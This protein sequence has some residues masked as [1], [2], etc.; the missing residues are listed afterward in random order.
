MPTITDRVSFPNKE[1]RSTKPLHARVK[2]EWRNGRPELFQRGI[3][4]NWNPFFPFIVN[5]IHDLGF[6]TI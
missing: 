4:T 3:I 2:G 1:K 6:P 5:D